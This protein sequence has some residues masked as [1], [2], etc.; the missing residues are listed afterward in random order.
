MTAPILNAPMGGVAGYALAAAVSKAGGLGMIGIGSAGSAE[1]LHELL[2]RTGELVQPSG[3][4]LLG[5]AIETEPQL[6]SIALAA[7]PTIVSVSFGDDWTWIRRAH[8]AGVLAVTQVA[9]VSNALRAVEAGVDVVVAR[10]AEGGGHGEP[11][12]GTLPLLTGI[13]D[14]V[15]VPVIAAGGIVSGRG[16]AAVLAAGASAAWVGTAFSVCPESMLTD[17]ARNALLNAADTDTTTTRVF[18]VAAGYPWPPHQ[19]ERVLRNAFSDRWDGNEDELRHDAD[20][21][22]ELTEA[23]A[24]GQYRL[25]PINAGQG[26]SSVTTIRPAAELIKQF[27]SDAA[28]LL[29]RR[30]DQEPTAASRPRITT[31]ASLRRHD[32]P[33]VMTDEQTDTDK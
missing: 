6:L 1:A 24:D 22:A 33:S 4:G 32:L 28:A 2:R 18:D 11:R 17:G 29:H 16:L 14:R 25:A 26:V 19:P 3:I 9:D 8:D 30:Y 7:R 20:A 31:P 15:D 12:V 23:I 5:W 13:L 21:L 10:G 27:C